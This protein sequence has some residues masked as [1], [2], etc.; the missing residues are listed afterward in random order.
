MIKYTLKR[1]LL[2]FITLFVLATV[3]FFLMKAIPGSPFGAEI[4]QLPAATVEKLYAKYNLDKSIPEQYVIYLKNV[5]RGDFGE[6]L[7]RKG[8]DVTTIIAKAAPVTMKLGAVAFVF[9]MLVGITFGHCGGTDQTPLDQQCGDGFWQRWASA[10]PAFLFALM[11]MI[12]FGVQLQIL[13][14]RSSVP[15]N[16]IMPTVALSSIPFPWC[17]VWCAPV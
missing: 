1:L 14:T 4:S 10:F 16:Y 8:T 2:G 6:S 9:S 17:P 11:L 7:L 12:V 15:L 5:I 13:N 3:T